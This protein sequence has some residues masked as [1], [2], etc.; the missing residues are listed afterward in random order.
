MAKMT[1]QSRAL[2]FWARVGPENG[3]G[4]RE[5]LGYRAAGY[6]QLNWQGVHTYAHR[7]AYEL[8]H[9]PIPPGRYLYQVLHTCDNPACCQPTH[10]YLGTPADNMRDRDTRGRHG[11]RPRHQLKD[12][13]PRYGSKN[14]RCLTCAA[15]SARRYHHRNRDA[16]L[17]RMRTYYRRRRG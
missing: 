1:A 3:R 16:V 14:Q 2:R 13:K 15:E 9:G 17:A 7:V 5:W 10:L 6:G 4:C 12:H 8:T 11:S